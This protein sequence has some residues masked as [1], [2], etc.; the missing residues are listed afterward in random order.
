MHQ[1]RAANPGAAQNDPMPAW[2]IGAGAAVIMIIGPGIF[3]WAVG[4]LLRLIG[5]E[6]FSVFSA[7]VEERRAQQAAEWRAAQEAAEI[8][9]PDPSS[10]GG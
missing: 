10:E 2:L 3:R 5:R 4:S 9:P 1:N 8:T 6:G 7:A